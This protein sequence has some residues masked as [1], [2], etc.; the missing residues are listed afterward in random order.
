MDFIF[1]L[2]EW[3]NFDQTGIRFPDNPARRVPLY[4]RANSTHNR[5]STIR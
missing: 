1:V 5:N 2:D 3:E 4:R